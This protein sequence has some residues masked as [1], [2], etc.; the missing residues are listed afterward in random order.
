VTG[1]SLLK[2]F[3]KISVNL[4]IASSRYMSHNKHI[5]TQEIQMPLPTLPP[6]P[7]NP[8]PNISPTTPGITPVAPGISPATPSTPGPTGVVINPSSQGSSI[9]LAGTQAQTNNNNAT[10]VTN[11]RNSAT[12]INEIKGSRVQVGDIAYDV[13]SFGLSA[14]VNQ[15]GDLDVR[16]QFS[17]PLGG[18]RVR[19][20]ASAIADMRA[21]AALGSLCKSI[22]TEGFTVEIVAALYPDMPQLAA[23][24]VSNQVI[25]DTTR[26]QIQERREAMEAKYSAQDDEIARLK[27]EIKAMQNKPQTQYPVQGLW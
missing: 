3:F 11:L 10:N 8:A 17:M 5:V 2:P 14:G 21:K 12:F 15:Y 1:S 6:A 26:H 20:S 9:D 24:A 23:C 18:R 4:L 22:R 25:V 16:A 13:P 7:A 19:K 27:A